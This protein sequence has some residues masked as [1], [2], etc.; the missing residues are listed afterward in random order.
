MFNKY[1]SF[2]LLLS[3]L[4]MLSGC[5]K[6]DNNLQHSYLEPQSEAPTFTSQIT[7]EIPDVVSKEFSRMI[8]E[9]Y[10][11]EN[12]TA[13]PDFSGEIT[14]LRFNVVHREYVS[15]T[16]GIALLD[17][18][19]K[20]R[21]F[22]QIYYGYEM[23]G[24]WYD[25]PCENYKL[26]GIFDL[27]HTPTGYE[28]AGESHIVKIGPYLVICV[29][30]NS[31]N[32]PQSKTY[33]KFKDTLGSKAVQCF[34]AYY[35]PRKGMDVNPE[36]GFTLPTDYDN[37]DALPRYGYFKENAAT[38]GSGNSKYSASSSF[39]LYY[40]LVLEYDSIPK[41]YKLE[42][43][44]FTDGLDYMDILTYEDIIARIEG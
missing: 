33:C 11:P 34:S 1:I 31:G 32:Y 23:D 24:Q 38:I 17:N 30:H 28:A 39:D 5:Q 3:L 8:L 29:Q 7:E 16:T 21:T 10:R 12:A 19:L 27:L 36:E 6:Q 40:F 25:I 41:D 13:R 43:F 15:K 20:D 35:S 4:M 14:D 9:K 37:S 44:Y 26:K 22:L 42:V 18:S 2:A